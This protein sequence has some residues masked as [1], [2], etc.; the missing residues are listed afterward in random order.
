VGRTAFPYRLAVAVLV[1]ACQRGPQKQGRP[2]AQVVVE[3]AVAKAVPV[4][5]TAVGTAVPVNTITVRAHVSGT[6]EQVLFREGDE[7]RAG[8][9]IFQIDARPFEA[10]L[11][12]ARATLL[13]D[14][15]QLANAE[16]EA[17]RYER[18]LPS[19]VVS[20]SDLDARTAAAQSLRATV[21][22]DKA[23]IDTAQLNLE[24]TA[25]RAPIAGLTG[26]LQVN[27]GNL[28]RADD[29]AL[30]VLRQMRP[31]DIGFTV[32]ATDLPAVRASQAR[33]P[34]FVLAMPRGAPSP[35]EGRL[36]F[37]DNTVD[38]G[39][40]TVLMKARFP[41]AD[42]ALWPGQFADV[43][44][45]LGTRQNVVVIPERAVAP[46]Q[47][48]DRVYVV[49]NDSVAQ[50]RVVRTGPRD[51]DGIVIEDGVAAGERVVVDG[52]LGL[53]PGAR[54][55]FQPPAEP[56]APTRTTAP[57]TS[58]GTGSPTISDR[59]ALGMRSK[60]NP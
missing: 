25:I 33:E 50:S 9:L 46:G 53:A 44:L 29:M 2:P 54:V 17:Q 5:I 43:R 52:L 24:Y 38:P 22:A 15:A 41:N 48:G 56:P 45:R 18:L 30:V 39:T 57:G 49:G 26:S 47:G 14:E 8:Q 23:A 27:A 19:G 40:G 36:F 28:V 32:P 37:V 4:E 3:Y 7:T 35:V 12:S 20:Q 21:L 59:H 42:E 13:R 58:P 1:L 16:I 10:A 55:E 34:L 11:A 60:G 6:L 51:Q 31:M